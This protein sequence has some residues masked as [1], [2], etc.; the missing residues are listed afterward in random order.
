MRYAYSASRHLSSVGIGK[1]TTCYPKVAEPQDPN[2]HVTQ[3]QSLLR[4]RTLTLSFSSMRIKRKKK[5]QEVG[6]IGMFFGIRIFCL[7]PS[8]S[9][10]RTSYWNEFFV[11]HPTPE[12]PTDVAN[13]RIMRLRSPRIASCSLSTFSAIVVVYDHPVTFRLFK[14]V[15]PIIALILTLGMKS[16]KAQKLLK[17]FR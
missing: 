4:C 17:S 13:V 6:T 1:N 7:M 16:P 2:L 15:Q 10:R 14:P 5:L 3:P 12:V 8:L 11:D 9:L